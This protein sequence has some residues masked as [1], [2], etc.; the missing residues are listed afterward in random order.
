MLKECLSYTLAI[1]LSLSG[2]LTTSDKHSIDYQHYLNGHKRVVVIAHGFYTSKE[3]FLLQ[4]LGGE[5]LDTYDIFMFDWRGHGKS[6]GFFSWTRNEDKDFKAVLDYLNNKYENIGVVAF[7]LGA[8][9]CI[10][11]LSSDSRVDGL[12]CVA[13]PSEFGRI[14]YQFWKLSPKD[15]LFYTLISSKGRKGK[16]IRPGLF[17]LKKQKPVENVTKLK[18]PV[19]YIHGE[20]DWVIKPWHSQALFDKTNSKKKLVIIKNGPHA[21][22]LMKESAEVFLKE[23]REW[24][25]E[26]LDTVN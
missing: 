10:N 19:L 16:G 2:K 15:D 1:P 18:I 5:L 12:I 13:A 3:D 17:W 24:L 4:K 8:A 7:S 6:S 11:A 22:Y 21:E 20:K 14:D 25:K 9:I 26:T 23:I